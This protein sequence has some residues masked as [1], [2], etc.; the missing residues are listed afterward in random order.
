MSSLPDTP[1]VAPMTMTAEE[2]AERRYVYFDAGSKPHDAAKLL[3]IAV[4]A[5]ALCDSLR[6]ALA[7]LTAEREGDRK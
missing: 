4:G 7:R 5:F 2:K 6:A 1:P 3:Q